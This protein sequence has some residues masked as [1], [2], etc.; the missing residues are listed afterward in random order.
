M[1]KTNTEPQAV[2][3]I[4]QDEIKGILENLKRK[5]GILWMRKLALD[6][7]FIEKLLCPLCNVQM[8]HQHFT[9]EKQY[10]EFQISGTCVQCQKSSFSV[11]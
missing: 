11:L 1:A 8:I 7:N 6:P 3:T 4:N 2:E 5:P 9:N 10:R